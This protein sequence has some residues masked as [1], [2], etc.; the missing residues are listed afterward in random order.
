MFF[1][2]GKKMNI[3]LL[4]IILFLSLLLVSI[5]IIGYNY[6]KSNE[7]D[8]TVTFVAEDKTVAYKKFNADDTSVKEPDVPNKKGYTGKWADYE[9]DG[10]D[11]TVQAEYAPIIYNVFFLA[12]GI[13]CSTYEYSIENQSITEPSVPDK[14]GYFGQ[15]EEYDLSN[16]GDITVNAVYTVVNRCSISYTVFPNTAG[17]LMGMTNQSVPRGSSGTPV[18]V[19]ANQ[20]YIF[21]GWS[22]GSSSATHMAKKVTDN[23]QVVANFIVDTSEGVPCICINTNDRSQIESRDEY[24]ECTI[25]I[26]NCGDQFAVEN[27]DAQIK[28]RGNGSWG[29][30]D[31]K[32]YKIKFN[33]KINLFEAGK[34]PAKDWVLLANVGERSMLRNYAVLHLGQLL[35]GIDYTSSCTYVEVYLNGEYVGVYILCEQV[36]VQ[37][38]RVNVNDK[39][40][41]PEVGFLVELDSYAIDYPFT[42]ADHT[43][44]IKS[45]VANDDQYNYIVNY[46]TMVNDAIVSGDETA[47]ESLVD[48]DSLIDMYLLQEFT[49]NIDVGWSSF[50]MYKDV[51]GKL[52]F[53]PPWDFD[54]S[55]GNDCRLDNGSYDKFYCGDGTDT[56]D[57][58]Q[59][60][61][62][63]IALF[64]CDW[65]KKAV[66][67]RW[68]AISDTVN[69]VISDTHL[70]GYDNL[71]VFMHNYERWPSVIYRYEN[72]TMKTLSSVTGYIDYLVEWMQNRKAWLDENFAPFLYL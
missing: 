41:T 40:D 20:G 32:P 70:T 30:T 69:K 67:L 31:K 50:F 58:D 25:S 36:E 39:T 4:I 72:E 42:I 34:G 54:L 56:L 6:K 29:L 57:H 38:S 35:D 5:V 33:N 16:L 46:I 19:I 8:Y 22:D 51:G 47:I 21:I 18:T 3:F 13:K 24:K 1:L 12:D 71:S 68:F 17:S 60:N 53:G 52:C 23:M 48:M 64:K 63:F 37:A 10:E 49:K 26:Y 66:A 27:L 62:W 65:F 7:G 28:G 45:N 11:I 14:P 15:W 43:Y 2:T 61:E 59:D 44:E 55:M 9:L